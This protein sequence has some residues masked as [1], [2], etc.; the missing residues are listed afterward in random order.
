MFQMGDYHWK[1]QSSSLESSLSSCV[2]SDTTASPS[3]RSIGQSARAKM[4]R[5]RLTWEYFLAV[6]YWERYAWIVLFIFY[7]CMWGLA[8]HRGFHIH[9]QEA[10]QD[11][12]KSFAGD[13]L[14]F[15]VGC[16]RTLQTVSNHSTRLTRVPGYCVLF[17]GV[18][19]AHRG[20]FQLSTTSQDQCSQS[21]SPD[22]VRSH[23]GRSSSQSHRLSEHRL[24]I[25]SSGST[26]VPR[27]RVGG[28][29]DCARLRRC[30]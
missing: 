5:V 26:L 13:F 29:D 7:L 9:D 19:G 24:N 2:L 15:G 27:N 11:T 18:L 23:G 3:P 22:L 1:R 8:S 17:V 21:L 16:L 20:G 12:G 6:H 10:K 28:T 25:P 4:I 30:V 14:S